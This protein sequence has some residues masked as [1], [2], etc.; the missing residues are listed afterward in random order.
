MPRTSPSVIRRPVATRSS[1]PHAPPARTNSFAGS[2]G[3]TTTVLQE[4]AVN[5]SGGQRQRI[6]LAR[7]LLLEPPLLLLDEPT[8]A[9]DPETEHEVLSSIERATAG[10]TTFIVGSRLS[11]LRSADLILVLDQGRIV[12]RG[13]HAA[14]MREK[15]LYFRAAALQTADAE[16]LDFVGAGT[17][18]A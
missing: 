2:S 14:L 7:A 9:I 5:L 1:G 13:S 16:R 3:V 10:R 18:G 17:V 15:G 12:E 4:G 6:A 11:S 8:A